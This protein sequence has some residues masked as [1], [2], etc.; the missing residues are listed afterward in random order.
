MIK[1]SDISKSF[2]MHVPHA[3]NFYGKLEKLNFDI[4]WK[5]RLFLIKTSLIFAYGLEKKYNI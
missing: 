5:K 2:N 4:F 1:T 3:T